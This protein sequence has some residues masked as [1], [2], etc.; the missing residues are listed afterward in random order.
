MS[1]RRSQSTI[2]MKGEFMFCHKK[3]MSIAEIAK[4]YDV[5]VYTIY[6]ML[7]EIADENGVTRESLLQIVHKS[8]VNT[9]SRDLNKKVNKV[10]AVKIVDGFSNLLDEINTFIE[11]IEEVKIYA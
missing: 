7:Q 4:E 2:K 11:K 1:S 3:G 8:H 10:E 6:D 5:S 9:A